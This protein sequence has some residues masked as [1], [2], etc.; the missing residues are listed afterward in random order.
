MKKKMKELNAAVIATRESRE[1]AYSAYS[2]ASTATDSTSEVDLAVD[3]TA[4]TAACK[5]TDAAWDAY[6][7]ACK[8][9]RKADNDSEKYEFGGYRSANKKGDKK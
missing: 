3:V 6:E 4:Y 5:A 2:A 7:T 9:A 8:L 1:Q